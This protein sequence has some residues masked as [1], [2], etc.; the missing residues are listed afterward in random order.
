MFGSC[1]LVRS[2]GG[3]DIVLTHVCFA[4]LKILNSKRTASLRLDKYQSSFKNILLGVCP[5]T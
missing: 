2:C 1:L 3:P 4:G 5:L